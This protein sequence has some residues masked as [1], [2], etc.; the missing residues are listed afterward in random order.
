M[1]YSNGLD[2]INNTLCHKC[3]VRQG[4]ISNTANTNCY[5]CNGILE[6]LDEFYE[7]IKYALKDYEFKTFLIGATIPLDIIERE[8]E[9][10]SKLKIKGR[11]IKNEITTT[12]SKIISTNMNVK[13]SFTD[14][15]IIINIDL[16]GNFVNVRSKSIYLLGR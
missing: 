16:R 7:L 9:F 1:D 12:L 2:L 5:I 4:I 3:Q 6:R 15:D 14:P 8:D 10:R 13:H 11:S